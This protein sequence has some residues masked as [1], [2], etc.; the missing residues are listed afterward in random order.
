MLSRVI[1]EYFVLLVKRWEKG[2]KV[3]AKNIKQLSDQIQNYLPLIIIVPAILG[4]LWQVLELSI[5][6]ISFIRFFS[7][8]QLLPDGLLILFLITIFMIIY[9]MF[10]FDKKYKMNLK[11]EIIVLNLQK[12]ASHLNYFIKKISSNKLTYQKNPIYSQ[13]GLHIGFIIFGSLLLWLGSYIVLNDLKKGFNIFLFFLLIVLIIV[14]GKLVLRSLFVLL[15]NVVETKFF[16]NKIKKF[17]SKNSFILEI[18]ERLAGMIIIMFIFVIIGFIVKFMIFFHSRYMLPDN[19]ENL[20]YLEQKLNSEDYNSSRISYTND[21]YIFIEHINHDK[22]TTYE[23]IK[24]DKL[25]VE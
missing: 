22:N 4:G 7:P 1:E 2:K 11:R 12:P 14:F 18:L 10:P 23:I 16:N 15:V 5:M 17:F 13:I 20:K 6:S 19:L 21:K 8:T 25:F 9:K 24:F 3:M